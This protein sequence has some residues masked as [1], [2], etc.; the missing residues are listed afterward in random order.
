M[1]KS[2]DE[3]RRL[4]AQQGVAAEAR[5]LPFGLPAIDGHLP[6]GGLACGALHE[7]APVAEGDTPAAFG[8]VAAM[9]G[10]IPPGGAA[11]SRHLAAASPT[12]VRMAMA[13]AASASIR[14]G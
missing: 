12:A 11:L 9:L 13:S 14:P 5:A 7:V 3:L 4:L 2:F 10:R 8:F 1:L 6:Q